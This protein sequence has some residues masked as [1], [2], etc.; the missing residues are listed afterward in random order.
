MSALCQSSHHACFGLRRS[1]SDNSG[2]C[3][4]APESK[5]VPKRKTLINKH[6][7]SDARCSG[8][9]ALRNDATDML[10][11]RLCPTPS[12]VKRAP[13]ARGAELHTLL[14]E[15]SNDEKASNHRLLAGHCRHV[16]WPAGTLLSRTTRSQRKGRAAP[17]TPSGHAARRFARAAASPRAETAEHHPLEPVEQLRKDMIYD[18]TLSN[19]PG[20]ACFQCH[21]PTTDYTSGSTRSSIWVPGRS[22]GSSRAGPEIASPRPTPTRHSAPWGRTTTPVAN[23]GSAATSGTVASPTSRPRPGAVIDPDEMAIPHER[24]LSPDRRY[25]AL[26][27]KKVKNGRIPR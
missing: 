25:S 13:L 26:L 15:E 1:H 10:S 19:P 2:S 7:T 14:I 27:V 24:D 9:P 17:S 12:F 5:E 21:A 16:R 4:S 20:Y 18:N 23:R 22:R 11:S 3:Q 6:R 8:Q